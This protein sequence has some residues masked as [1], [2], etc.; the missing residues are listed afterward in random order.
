MSEARIAY[1]EGYQLSFHRQSAASPPRKVQS[2]WVVQDWVCQVEYDGEWMTFM[3]HE[4][5][6][7]MLEPSSVQ[8]V[9]TDF[10]GAA[11]VEV[12]TSWLMRRLEEKDSRRK[13]ER[14]LYLCA[15]AVVATLALAV[16]LR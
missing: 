8:G 14:L 4:F 2:R 3:L 5:N 13:R 15:M 11:A 1:V 12:T 7:G 16:L 6:D 10:A 9:F